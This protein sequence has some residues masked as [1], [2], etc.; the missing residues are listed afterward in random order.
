LGHGLFKV[1]TKDTVKQ[2]LNE[3]L[4]MHFEK[5]VSVDNCTLLKDAY[6]SLILMEGDSNAHLKILGSTDVSDSE[7]QSMI[8]Q[9]Y[10]QL[11]RAYPEQ[12]ADKK[13]EFV[14]YMGGDFKVSKILG[15]DFINF[16]A[17]IDLEELL[18]QR[19]EQKVKAQSQGSP[20]SSELSFHTSVRRVRDSVDEAMNDSLANSY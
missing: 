14:R 17:R 3:Q 4:R 11:S 1:V 15:C 16:Q 20:I 5:K 13:E 10:Q 9:V 2:A 7:K 12:C 6:E 18:N 8:E 19:S